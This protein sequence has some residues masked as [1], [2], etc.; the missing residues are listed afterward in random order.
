MGSVRTRD[1]AAWIAHGG[2]VFRFSTGTTELSGSGMR[3]RRISLTRGGPVEDLAY[4]G[5]TILV[6]GVLWLIVK[7]VERFER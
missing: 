7:G 6:F 5:L 4:I 2:D 3:A 1:R